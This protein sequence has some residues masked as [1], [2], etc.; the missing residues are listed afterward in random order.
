MVREYR[1]AIFF[2]KLSIL[3]NG[4]RQ[5]LSVLFFYVLNFYAEV[6][7]Y[8][9]ERTRKKAGCLLFLRWA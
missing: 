7:G 6:F 9:C 8:R 2:S 1:F 5:G 4:Y 3:D